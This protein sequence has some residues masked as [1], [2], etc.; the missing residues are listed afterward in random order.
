M[1]H[2]LGDAP[3]SLIFH[4][5]KSTQ[6][7]ECLGQPRQP[8]SR[9]HWRHASAANLRICRTSS[10]HHGRSCDR[11]V[12]LPRPVLHVLGPPLVPICFSSWLIDLGSTKNKLI[13]EED[14]QALIRSAVGWRIFFNALGTCDSLDEAPCSCSH[15]AKA[16]RETNH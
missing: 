2:A 15:T 3:Q 1:T 8:C 6:Y 5:N 13:L 9:H 10:Q 12:P 4:H 16:E 11:C 7:N 14:T